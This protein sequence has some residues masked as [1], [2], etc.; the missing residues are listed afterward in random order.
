ML[1]PSRSPLSRINNSYRWRFI[2]KAG[3]SEAQRLV[4]LLSEASDSFQRKRRKG[5]IRLTVDINP[6]NLA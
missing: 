6:V 5:D 4:E 3:T 2:I 1:G